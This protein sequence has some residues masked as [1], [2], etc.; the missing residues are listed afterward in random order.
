MATRV[1]CG[2]AETTISFDMK[3]PHGASAASQALQARMRESRQGQRG[4]EGVR[5]LQSSFPHPM[6]SSFLKCDYRRAMRRRRDSLQTQFTKRL[7]RT[8][9]TKPRAKNPKIVDEPP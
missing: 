5:I 1:S 8:F 6:R 2:F 3:T 4:S 7:V 9:I